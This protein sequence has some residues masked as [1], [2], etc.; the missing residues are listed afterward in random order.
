VAESKKDE[1]IKELKIAV[2]TFFGETPHKSYD[3]GKV[4]NKKQYDRLAAYLQE[5]T[6]AYGGGLY[7]ELL[8]IEPTILTDVQMQHTI[9]QEEIFGPILP[10]IPISGMQAGLDIIKENKNPLAFYLFTNN[11]KK[12]NK[13]LQAVPFGG[14]CI[15]NASVH[16][17][18]DNLPFGGRGNS[19]IGH[20]H[21]KYSFEVF[22]HKKS[23]LRNPT[24][25][26]PKIKYPSYEGKLGLLKKVFG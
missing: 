17:I 15:N 2:T 9:M 4:I 3:Y 10:V 8:V 11:K 12:K 22:S 23:V 26:D 20:Y 21:G 16:L 19:G 13:W 7:P 25:F 14:G 6:I 5:G 24:W 18:N 1:L